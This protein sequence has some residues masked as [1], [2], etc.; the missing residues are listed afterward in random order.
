MKQMNRSIISLI[1]VFSILFSSV[2]FTVA[3]GE[4]IAVNLNDYSP[5]DLYFTSSGG[6][7]FINSVNV[8]AFDPA[9]GTLTLTGT[10]SGSVTLD[11]VTSFLNV[12]LNG[13]TV[14]QPASGS[15]PQSGALVIPAG[16]TVN[17]TLVE[18]TLNTFN[19][20]IGISGSTF[21]KAGIS[22]HES[23]TLNIEGD[24]Q[25]SAR[26][27]NGISSAGGGAGI[28]SSGGGSGDAPHAGS[29]SIFGGIISAYGGNGDTSSSIN[30][31]GGHARSIGGGGGRGGS[32][33]TA[34]DGGYAKYIGIHGGI[35]NTNTSGMG[36][37]FGGS[38]GQ[39]PTPGSWNPGGN[40]G[41][42]IIDITGGTIFVTNR[43]PLSL[44]PL[45]GGG[46][47]GSGH[48]YG[49][50]GNGGFSEFSI[51]H[52]TAGGSPELYI[53]NSSI[54]VDGG[55]YEYY[56]CGGFG[57]EPGP[58]G[59]FGFD[60]GFYHSRVDDSRI[61]L[62]EGTTYT[63]TYDTA[64]GDPETFFEFVELGEDVQK[65]AIIPVKEGYSFSAWYWT[66]YSPFPN[67]GK[68]T[69][70]DLV[71]TAHYFPAHVVTFDTDGGI[72]AT[73]TV[74]V[75]NGEKVD[76]PDELD[77]PV[78][79]GYV[80]MGW[81]IPN[82]NILFNFNQSIFG[83]TT[84]VARYTPTL[85]EITFDAAGGSPEPSDQ[86]VPHDGKVQEPSTPPLKNG[87]TFVEWRLGGVAYD[88]NATV[89][90]SFELVA[91]YD[92]VIT[93][94]VNFNTNGGLPTIPST[95]VPH[96][97]PVSQP[98][99][100]AKVGYNF[101]EWRYQNG[102][103]Y[104][105]TT[106]VTADLTLYAAYTENYLDTV[107]IKIY[108]YF[109]GFVDSAKT[110]T[111]AFWAG[112]VTDDKVPTTFAGY[113]LDPSMPFDPALP[114]QMIEGEEL[115]V[116]LVTDASQ[117]INIEVEYY[118]DGT[119]DSSKTIASKS[120]PLAYVSASD[121]DTTFA[122]Y[123]LDPTTPFV[124]TLPVQM[125]NGDTLKVYLVTD[126]TDTVA[127]TVEY[128]IDGSSTPDASM[129]R[130]SF[131]VWAFEVND[132]Q[133]PV[134]AGYDLD[135]T[136]PFAPVLPVQ[137]ADND[138]L[139]VYLVKN[140]TKTVNITV[141]YY[142]NGTIDTSKTLVN[143]SVW[144]GMVTAADIPTTFAGYVLNT[145]TPF[146]PA[147]PVQMS[148]GDTLKVYLN[149]Q[150]GNGGGGNGTGGA[151]IVNPSEQPTPS[152]QPALDDD[153]SGGSGR[154]DEELP[155]IEIIP[156]VSWFA[157]FLIYALAILCGI[158]RIWINRKS[159]DE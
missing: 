3:A 75:A 119:I 4:S 102:T 12:D 59:N 129:T 56:I 134:P 155:P 106:P 126:L 17:L 21:G 94:Q 132:S 62:I 80:F 55:D 130:T 159:D 48:T 136:T 39:G 47:G 99:D 90:S 42:S 63:I 150:G 46:S 149:S 5:G 27:G 19:G 120:V 61:Y 118:F 13:V 100:P 127:I 115:S 35:V 70:T 52:N 114:K 73:Y 66:I 6:N 28:G 67:F 88:F 2:G 116:Y 22:V 103:S 76:Q 20:S 8:G 26:G 109:D 143:H 138:I 23:A 53:L 83:N 71:L 77:E 69:Y 29:I 89:H 40:G 98:Q 111:L 117:T 1:L 87:Y 50:G 10:L 31:L 34:S 154:D 16:R 147:L 96:G 81:Y 57:G 64:G 152:E 158:F 74:Y 32:Q 58:A 104:S 30:G 9:S 54:G 36:G 146:N 110:T 101:S 24:G 128:Y 122:G 49:D 14:N 135:P 86:S 15:S 97:T 121:I 151:I 95:N 141:E 82:T 144:A 84:I 133:I 45:I 43:L 131:P 137:M 38:G 78:K 85:Y 79:D 93:H 37:G 139:K 125:N 72:P 113:K 60:A 105:F 25:L 107:H 123:M 112:E 153:G 108:Y 157:M 51:M 91:H 7:L 140:P 44:S 18:G 68:P 11:I 124:P 41:E 148:W 92:Q 142:F 65:T 156:K 145:T 33:E